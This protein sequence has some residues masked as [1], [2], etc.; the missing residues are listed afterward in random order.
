MTE[1]TNMIYQR[2]EHLRRLS[3]D[4][5]TTAYE[6]ENARVFFERLVAAYPEYK[7]KQTRESQEQVE[8]DLRCSKSYQ[9]MLLARIAGF[10]GCKAYH[11][12]IRGKNLKQLRIVGPETMVKLCQDLYHDLRRKQSKAIYSFGMGFCWS[13]I[14]WIPADDNP[15]G[16]KQKKWGA[17]QI[18]IMKAGLDAGGKHEV[19]SLNEMLPEHDPYLDG[20][21]NHES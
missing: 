21:D 18:E 14:P 3:E 9:C 2:I 4:K 19:K 5:S 12:Q 10:L 16:K 11:L 8:V 7:D 1:G 13:A 15:D 6:R 20:I 17:D